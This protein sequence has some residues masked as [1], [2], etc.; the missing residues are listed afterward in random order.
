MKK[1][2]K[3]VTSKPTFE[4]ELDE[5]FYAMDRRYVNGSRFLY[6]ISIACFFFGV[7]GLIWMIPF[8]QFEFLISVNMHTFLNWGSFYI[9]IIIYFYLRLAPTLSYAMLFTIGIMS[10]FIVQ[11]EYL[12]RDG[13]PAVWLVS[14]M[15]A[16]FGFI[17]L[18]LN[19]RRESPAVSLKELWRLITIGPIWYWSKAFNKLSIKY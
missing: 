4:R 16:I 7:M 18:Y 10:F 11:F 12:E 1:R 6:I 13:G 15:F 3:N 5:V 2:D 8:P 14:L 9:A 19:S 17:G